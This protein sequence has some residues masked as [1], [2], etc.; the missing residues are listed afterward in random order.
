VDPDRYGRVAFWREDFAGQPLGR[1]LAPLRPL[2]RI[3][4]PEVGPAEEIEVR[5]AAGSVAPSAP[6]ELTADLLG[7]DGRILQVLLGPVRPGRHAY[8]A[9]VGAGGAGA[10][11]S[12][13]LLR[14]RLDESAELAGV[15]GVYRFEAVRARQ[16]G[17][18]RPVGGFDPGRWYVRGAQ[19]QAL[20]TT[21]AAGGRALAF[22][23][24][25][26]PE[27]RVTVNSAA[28]PEELPAVVTTGLLEDTGQAVG[29]LV[30][31]RDAQGTLLKLKV[32]GVARALPGTGGAVVAALV[33][34][35][36]LLLYGRDARLAG[37]AHLWAA[38]GPEATAAV[39]RLEGQGVEIEDDLT[40][41]QRRDDLGRQPPALALLLLLVGAT[42]A[43]VLATG[44]VMLYLYLDGRRRRFELAVLGALGARHRDLWQPLALEHAVLVGWG[45]LAGGAVGLATAL[46]ALPAVP[47]FLDPPRVPPA[48]HLPDWPVLTVGAGL[49]LA[50]V[51]AGVSLV[52]AGL[53]RAARP[54]LLREEVL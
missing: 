18:W 29:G 4:P 43:A 8:R 14:V 44:G 49:A 15:A 11:E 16:G 10:A 23:L 13:R 24:P 53:V 50:L 1:L 5:L 9:V 30:A 28:V 22:A 45:V 48:L 26:D 3:P 36:G 7:G 25:R 46:V 35:R 47:Q 39:G 40:A 51:A 33:D 17:R 54:E 20:P 42:S 12:Y 52:V 27:A 19:G 21:S 41:G 31:V 37:R 6:P 38:A 34:L 2:A 32:T